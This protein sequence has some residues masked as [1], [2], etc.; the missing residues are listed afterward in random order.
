MLHHAHSLFISYL[1]DTSFSL[2]HKKI[3]L[4]CNCLGLIF[5]FSLKSIAK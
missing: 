1:K 4:F 3:I 2:R 5:F